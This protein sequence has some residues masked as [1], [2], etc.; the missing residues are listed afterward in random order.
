MGDDWPHLSGRS[1]PP[2]GLG[3]RAGTIAF[4]VLKSL[5]IYR[6]PAACVH[7][8]YRYVEAAEH[9]CRHS[10]IHVAL[11]L[12]PR[13]AYR[14]A[15]SHEL[16]PR[17]LTMRP[18]VLTGGDPAAAASGPRTFALRWRQIGVTRPAILPARCSP[19]GGGPAG[20]KIFRRWGPRVWRRMRGLWWGVTRLGSDATATAGVG[21]PAGRQDR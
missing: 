3:N 13:G 7:G 16:E 6:G 19:P 12:A 8:I 1:A 17:Q 14:P 2:K 20:L 10:L 15:P 21:G 5:A 11:A 18:W 4:N 9:P